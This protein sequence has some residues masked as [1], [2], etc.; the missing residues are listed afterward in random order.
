M[1]LQYRMVVENDPE[2]LLT[3]ATDTFASWLSRRDDA[4]ELP[5]VGQRTLAGSMEVSSDQAEDERVS[6]RRHAVSE[7]LANGRW[8]TT[9]TA[10]TTPSGEGW[11]W[12]DLEWV[13]DDPYGRA[14]KV[15]APGLVRMLLARGTAHV[16][17]TPMP[18]EPIAV[19]SGEVGALVEV[20]H[21]PSRAVPVVVLSRDHV[22]S[23]ALN[24][25]RAQALSRELLGVAPVY[26]LEGSATSELN[27]ALAAGLH[28]VGGAV[29]TYLP[30]M[31]YHDPLTQRRH[32]VLGGS[33]LRD[34]LTTSVRLVTEPLRRQALATRPPA[35]YRDHGRLLLRRLGSAVDEDALL[36]DVLEAEQAAE[37]ARREA[38]Q[39]REDLEWQALSDADTERTLDQVQARLRWLESL[40]AEQG[41]YVQGEATPGHGGTDIS[42]FEDV[43][44]AAGQ[45]KHIVLGKVDDGALTLDQYP[46]AESWARKSWRA[47]VALDEYAEARSQGWPGDFRAWCVA[48]A[49]VNSAVVPVTWVALSESDSVDNNP[50]YRDARI[51][52]VPGN[53]AETGQVYMAAHVKIVEGGRPAPRLHFHDD[54]AGETGRIYVGHLGP[55][56]PND[57]TN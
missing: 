54:T 23:T 26:M 29:R 56:L 18:A 3:A 33:R 32:R 30:G 28:V 52:S 43:L 42:G 49:E 12:T 21:D 53:V 36:N 51:F 37:E 38:E 4:P 13:S 35:T 15:A 44:N 50:K 39:L 2:G 16:G 8:T 10:I 45:L 47:L 48:P 9:L 31:G 25:H 57:Q 1:S 17:A 6:L 19:P 34:D 27:A 5:P 40:L 46:Q 14:P 55:H 7:D 41:R 20:L 11:L 24:R 22:A